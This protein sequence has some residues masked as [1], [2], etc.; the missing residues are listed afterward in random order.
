[1]GYVDPPTPLNHP[2]PEPETCNQKTNAIKKE[3]EDDI[4][5]S[6]H[7][8]EDEEVEKV[9]LADV[10]EKDEENMNA[11][12]RTETDLPRLNA[13]DSDSSDSD[14]DSDSD[15]DEKKSKGTTDQVIKPVEQDLDEDGPPV[16]DDYIPTAHEIPLTSIPIPVLPDPAT[17]P[18]E[19]LEL[20]GEIGT[21]LSDTIIIRGGGNGSGGPSVGYQT[22]AERR[23]AV[24]DEGS[25]LLFDDRTPLGYVWETFGPTSL[26]HYIVRVPRRIK[27]VP[28]EPDDVEPG[29]DTSNEVNVNALLDKVTLSRPVYS[30]R[31]TS[32]LVFTEA[33]TKLK[34]SDASN[35]H[36]EELSEH[37]QEFSDDEAE[38][39]F[40]RSRRKG[41]RAPSVSRSQRQY[42][43]HRHHEPFAHA[44]HNY[45]DDAGSLYGDSPYDM[46][47]PSNSSFYMNGSA[48]TNTNRQYYS[49]P[50]AVTMSSTSSPLYQNPEVQR[51][52]LNAR[53]SR[54]RNS[55]T[56][57]TFHTDSRTQGQATSQHSSFS[58][59]SFSYEEYDPRMP[60]PP[61]PTSLAIAQATGQWSNGMPFVQ[62]S[63]NLNMSAT[64]VTMAASYASTAPAS[65]GFHSAYHHAHPNAADPTAAYTYANVG[66]QMSSHSQLQ[67]P[68]LPS[69]TGTSDSFESHDA[70][71]KD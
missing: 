47:D 11:V 36:D 27:A 14:S 54:R 66:P 22:A 65:G 8:S 51:A 40:K 61:S 29:E 16:P 2:E 37:E 3:E 68:S 18:N 28:T 62:E 23:Q 15:E 9:L 4:S 59:R 31:S 45:I 6:R 7:E 33:L 49:A 55:S 38:A 5:S 67:T 53:L 35:L 57:G 39:A 1:M 52:L 64:S 32:K 10:A 71:M 19:P 25:L 63:A 24:L 21:I 56:A 43:Q 13:S 69:N 70:Q 26:P 50:A 60:R 42:Q 34:G 12:V 46:D 41:S 44:E 58:S 48:Q 20:V 17:L 30:L